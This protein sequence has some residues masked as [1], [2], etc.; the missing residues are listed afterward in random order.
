VREAFEL[1]IDREA[2][3]QVVWDGPLHARCT[4][5]P[6][7]SAFADKA[8]KCPGRDVAKAKKLLAEAGLAGGYAF[9]M[10]V[11]NNPA[12]AGSASQRGYTVTACDVSAEAL[13]T[14]RAAGGATADTPAALANN[15]TS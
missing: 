6:P 8:R 13:E 15:A 14:A 11:I 12:S 3:N 2:L 4:P 7:I 5:I 9:E 10:T 1:S